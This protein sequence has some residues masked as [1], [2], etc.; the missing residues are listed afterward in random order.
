M[1][2]VSWGESRLARGLSDLPSEA[3]LAMPI[4]SLDGPQF[5]DSRDQADGVTRQRRRYFFLWTVFFTAL[6]NALE[7]Q[8]LGTAAIS[9][10]Q[11]VQIILFLPLSALLSCWF[12]NSLVGYVAMGKKRLRASRLEPSAPLAHPKGRTAIL[13]PV[14]NEDP[15]AVA[16]RL[17]AMAR[18]L[19]GHGAQDAF[20]IFVLSDTRNRQVAAAEVEA[21]HDLS[22]A[23]PLPVYYRR[24]PENTHRKSGNL[25]EWVQRFGAAYPQMIV[26]DADSL[27]TGECMLRLVGEM[28]RRPDLGLI[29]TLPVIV[30]AKTLFARWIQFGTRV[31]GQV[32]SAGL[33]WWS[34]AE[35]AYWGH[36]AVIR[37]K[38]FAE[39][40]GLP[41]LK[42]AAPFGGHI[43]SHDVV[44]AGLMR[45]AGWT[46]M[47]EPTLPGSYEEA[48]PTVADFMVR[49]RRWCQGN[50]Q[51]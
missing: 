3:P 1:S 10:L 39:S 23:S 42:G 37:T 12:V 33:A 17:L 21:F 2:D 6:A 7:I 29:Q 36:N 18:S 46:V 20:D 41:E 45:R 25:A 35:A 31:Y 43:M 11:W 14:Y 9:P 48:P 26:L 28:E 30:G 50:V 51:H 22:A 16:G 4:Q 5:G 44:E 47:F 19:A 15:A 32:A 24:R 49:D 27:M 8:V 34:G 13:A 40:C 38:A